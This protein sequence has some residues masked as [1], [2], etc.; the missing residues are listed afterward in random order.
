MGNMGRGS[1][2]RVTVCA[3]P[4]GLR[5]EAIAGMAAPENRPPPPPLA[6]HVLVEDTRLVEPLLNTGTYSYY[7]PEL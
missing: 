3:L 2:V 6:A 5:Q 4:S 1:V 7:M